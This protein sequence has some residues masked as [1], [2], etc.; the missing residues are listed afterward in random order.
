MPLDADHYYGSEAKNYNH[1]A[2]SPK[3]AEED[4]L[5][6]EYVD[7]GPVLDVP[8]GTGRYFGW[9]QERGYEFTAIDVSSDMLREARKVAPEADIRQGSIFDLP[10]GQWNHVVCSR[11]AQ[12][13]YP[14]DLSRA[15][16]E[17]QRVGRVINMSIR[18][19]DKGHAHH[20]KSWTH[21]EDDMLD[22]LQGWMITSRDTISER[23]NCRYDLIQFRAPTYGDVC[24]WFNDRPKGTIEKLLS[25]FAPRVGLDP[26][27]PS[28][29][30]R[31][32]YWTADQHKALIDDQ[33]KF[34]PRARTTNPPRWDHGPIVV[35]EKNGHQAM[36]DGRH[37]AHQRQS[38]P[39]RHPVLIMNC[40]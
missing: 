1:R 33:A 10:D 16:A 27:G 23:N 21:S 18:V 20:Y 38:I 31:C 9:Y 6:R 14:E 2:K 39:G 26:F 35:V 3:W 32:E 17:M 8:C 37:R 29:N 7:G 5:Y 28:D 15:V 12:W 40:D 22:S 11:M 19:G 24:E 30:V 13:L 25:E 36:I 4:R 34:D